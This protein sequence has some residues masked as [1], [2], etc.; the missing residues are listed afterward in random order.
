LI[1]YVNYSKRLDKIE[2]T[3]KLS[4]LATPNIRETDLDLGSNKCLLF[5][6]KERQEIYSIRSL[7]LF[8]KKLEFIREEG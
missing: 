6:I 1:F 4:Q 8:N 3:D 5:Q 7:D 2:T